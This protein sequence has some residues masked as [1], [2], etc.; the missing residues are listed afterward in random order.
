MFVG[1]VGKWDAIYVLC[2]VAEWVWDGYRMGMILA[3]FNCAH[4]GCS[5]SVASSGFA[6]G[7]LMDDRLLLYAVE[8]W[9][10]VDLYGNNGLSRNSIS[11]LGLRF[12]FLCC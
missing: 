3:V 1:A 2:S 4:R 10:G 8:T 9:G 5:G 11:H 12:A 7:E 6:L